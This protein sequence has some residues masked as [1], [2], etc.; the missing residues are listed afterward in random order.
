MQRKEKNSNKKGATIG[1]YFH[2]PDSIKKA[3]RSALS[4]GGRTTW[5]W[6]PFRNVLDSTFD[7]LQNITYSRMLPELTTRYHSGRR[8]R[9]SEGASAT[10]L[11]MCP[12]AL[13]PLLCWQM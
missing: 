5:T 11:S 4:G 7:P 3:E 2:I 6:M 10:S 13:S 9:I 1:L 12:L 8:L